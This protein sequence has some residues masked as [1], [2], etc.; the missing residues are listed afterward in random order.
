MSL[1][2]AI[3]QTMEARGL[4]ASEVAHR[5]GAEY[6]L[7]TFYR[8]LNGSTTEPRLPTLVALCQVLEI[9]PS[10]LLDL[11][12]VWP[13]R[14]VDASDLQLR[15]LFARIQAL[16]LAEKRRVAHLVVAL[17]EGWDEADE[18]DDKGGDGEP[19]VP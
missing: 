17:A 3:T 13:R 2:D 15:Q 8:M 9:D 7:A 18:A 14:A 6:D 11:A 5:L 1:A 10:D 12:G 4:R 19:G 16:P